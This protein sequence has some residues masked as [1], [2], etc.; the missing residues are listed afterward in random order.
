[1][2]SCFPNHSVFHRLSA[3]SAAL[4]FLSAEELMSCCATGANGCL[5]LRCCTFLP[6]ERVRAECPGFMARLTG[7]DKTAINRRADTLRGGNRR[8]MCAPQIW[9]QYHGHRCDTAHQPGE[10]G[11]RQIPTSISCHSQWT[12]VPSTEKWSQNRFHHRKNER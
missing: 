7:F 8:V 3:Q 12:D 4:L 9:P 5:D 11:R 6:S 1:M 2:S 10:L